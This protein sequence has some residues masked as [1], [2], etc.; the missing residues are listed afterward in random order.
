MAD[1]D[2]ALSLIPGTHRIN[3]HASYAIF[4][5]GEW[6]DRDKLEPKH[7]AK[8]VE[9]AKE[10][11]LGLDFNPTYFSHPKA[12]EYTLTSP[13]EEIR[14]FWIEHGKAASDPLSI[15]LKNWGRLV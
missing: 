3:V 1:I 14:K 12:D 5:E 15:L 10:R 2:K 13:D 6:V 11:G 7:F 9:F 4:E 8:W